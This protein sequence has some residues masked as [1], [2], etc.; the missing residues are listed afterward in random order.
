M[1]ESSVEA[2]EHYKTCKGIKTDSVMFY[3]SA[4]RL[5][6]TYLRCLTVLGQNVTRIFMLNWPRTLKVWALE[7]A[8]QEVCLLQGS[9][10][11]SMVLLSNRSMPEWTSV[12]RSPIGHTDES[13]LLLNEVVDVSTC[14]H[15][16]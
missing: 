12:Q 2:P 9:G 4:L 13:T 5:F 7:Q 16:K 8:W 15:T 6:L 14:L 3:K 1:L 10:R 11:V